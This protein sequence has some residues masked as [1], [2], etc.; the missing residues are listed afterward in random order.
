[1]VLLT[2][3]RTN[4]TNFSKQS[5][6]KTLYNS[7]I[8]HVIIKIVASYYIYKYVIDKIKNIDKSRTKCSAW[9]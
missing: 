9:N 7:L 5:F 8:G 2:N 4:D 1:M 6:K 3:I